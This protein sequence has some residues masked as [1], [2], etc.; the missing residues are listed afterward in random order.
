MENGCHFDDTVYG[1]EMEMPTTGPGIT[2]VKLLFA[3]SSNRCAFPKCKAPMALD[4]TLVGEI[5]HIK[6]ARP[7]SARFDEAQSPTDRHH[8][9]NLILMCPTH[10]TVIDAIYRASAQFSTAWFV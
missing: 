1:L 4:D 10:H 6:G 2:D 7:G 8:R 9:D 3:K 5:C